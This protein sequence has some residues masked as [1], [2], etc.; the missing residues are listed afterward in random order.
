[1]QKEKDENGHSQNSILP[2]KNK[3]VKADPIDLDKVID[4][5]FSS[6]PDTSTLER[7]IS[8][9]Q[10]IDLM[11]DFWEADGLYD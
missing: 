9:S 4:T 2:K 3:T 10:V 11:I 5:L 8:L 1:M 6:K 7:P